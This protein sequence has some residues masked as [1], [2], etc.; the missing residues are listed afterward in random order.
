MTCDP[1]RIPPPPPRWRRL[2][3][4]M[5]LPMKVGASFGILGALLAV[6]GLIRGAFEPFSWRG[7]AMAVVLAGGS[8]GL[9]SWALTTAVIDAGSDEQ[10]TDDR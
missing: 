3:A 7:L 10:S 4:R 2:W 9:V 1:K 6:V 5:D 8:W